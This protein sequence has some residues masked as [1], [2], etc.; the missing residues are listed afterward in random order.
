MRIYL[1]AVGKR[2]PV[3]VNE[4]YRE[5]C[6]RMPRE[7]SV[8]LIE[9][10]AAKRRKTSKPDTMKEEEAG[11]ILRAIPNNALKVMLDQSGKP[12]TTENLSQQMADWMQMGSDVALVVGGADGLAKRC[13]QEAHVIWSLSSLTFPHAL[14]RVIV[15]EQ[16]YRAWTMLQGHP[17]HR[18]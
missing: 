13:L 12:W 8:H 15:A 7:L 5:F 16:L 6:K 2:M 18:S 14:V 1:V 4:A 9:V 17:Y 11:N 10:E 3:W